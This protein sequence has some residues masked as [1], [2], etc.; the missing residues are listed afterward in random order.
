MPGRRPWV[1]SLFAVVLGFVGFALMYSA[2]STD[3]YSGWPPVIA[4]V[5]LLWLWLVDLRGRSQGDQT[6]MSLPAQITALVVIV[7]AGSVI[8]A[9]T[10]GAALD[11]ADK[12]GLPDRWSNIMGAL[13]LGLLLFVWPE[14]LGLLALRVSRRRTPRAAVRA[15]LSWLTLFSFP[16]VG[17]SWVAYEMARDS[18]Q[19]LVRLGG[20]ELAFGRARDNPHSLTLLGA[21]IVLAWTTLPW[22]E[23]YLSERGRDRDAGD[24]Q[25]T[26][27][28]DTRP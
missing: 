13:W 7:P 20:L 22:L 25:A 19:L 11:I 1:T 14:V 27:A 3:D 4:A 15:M 10:L 21:L 26:R 17:L 16:A 18:P 5:Q 23:L 28:P 8:S 9:V 6:R 24:A 12:A 2:E